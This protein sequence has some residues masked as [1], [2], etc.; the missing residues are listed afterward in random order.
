MN[1]RYK[2]ICLFTMSEKKC[3]AFEK[4]LLAD[5]QSADTENCL[6]SFPVC[7]MILSALPSFNRSFCLVD[8]GDYLQKAHFRNQY[9]E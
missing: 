6:V 4:N 7:L 3:T 5:H 2:M 8:M 9:N 1:P